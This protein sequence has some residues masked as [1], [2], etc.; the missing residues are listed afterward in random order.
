MYEDSDPRSMGM[1]SCRGAPHP[2]S[3]SHAGMPGPHSKMLTVMGELPEPPS[4][5]AAAAAVAAAVDSGNWQGGPP[6]MPGDGGD[7]NRSV[8]PVDIGIK[9]A[10]EIMGLHSQAAATGRALE[11][12]TRQAEFLQ[13]ENERLKVGVRLCDL[14]TQSLHPE[15]Q[16][17]PALLAVLSAGRF[18]FES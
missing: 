18:P 2:H 14:K 16:L 9:V 4:P 8:N 1:P 17:R 5:A 10:N 12:S 3:P 15:P 11:E 6:P 13:E 7:M